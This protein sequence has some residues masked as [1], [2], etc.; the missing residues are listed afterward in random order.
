MPD[1]GA[2]AARS[3]TRVRWPYLGPPQV[4]LLVA[5]LATT[6]GSFL[7]WLDTGFGAVSGLAIGGRMTFYAAM[8]AVPGAAW[9]RR[10]VVI[11]HAAVLAAA[12][13]GVGGWQ[14]LS[15]FRRLPAFGQAWLPAPGLV[16]VLLSG[17]VAAVAVVLLVRA[18][19]PSRSGAP[20]G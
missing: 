15:A 5:G 16:L 11:A 7:P 20:W 4:M 14:L 1:S 17:A 3:R 6:V 8:L 19:H 10:G 18:G 12:A 9:R 13:L 2:T